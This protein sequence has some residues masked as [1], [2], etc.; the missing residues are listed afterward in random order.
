[1]TPL[2]DATQATNF[3]IKP[4]KMFLDIKT[5]CKYSDVG[6]RGTLHVNFSY[7]PSSPLGSV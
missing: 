5:S 6:T 7:T 3:K 4:V 2:I 1:M